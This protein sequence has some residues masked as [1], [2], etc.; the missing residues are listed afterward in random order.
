MQLPAW[1]DS[2]IIVGLLS[3]VGVLAGNWINRASR[4]EEISATETETL[5]RG[6]DSRIKALEARLDKVE[7]DLAET[8]SDLR[9]ERA[10]TDRLGLH[11]DQ[12]SQAFRD[13]LSWVDA[14][15]SWMYEENTGPPPE[16]PDFQRWK[17]V[18]D[19]PRP[20]RP[21]SD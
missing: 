9:Q 19:Q 8:R 7:S 21:P 15:I 13:A 16:R 12:L 17:D 10:H 2:A 20:R 1:V 14:A 3:L 6:Q 5:V 4:K 18:L 11:T